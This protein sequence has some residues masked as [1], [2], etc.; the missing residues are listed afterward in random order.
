MKARWQVASRGGV[1]KRGRRLYD[2]GNHRVFK[3][4]LWYRRRR[5]VHG[6]G[7]IRHVFVASVPDPGPTRRP[8]VKAS[9]IQVGVDDVLK[10]GHFS[11]P[12][13]LHGFDASFKDVFLHRVLFVKF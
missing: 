7:I 9:L 4:W 13:V 12:G 2:F 1:V 5:R 11:C 8:G 3:T 6:I 10:G